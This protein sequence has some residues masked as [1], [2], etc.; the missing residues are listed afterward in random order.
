MARRHAYKILN[1]YFL[2]SSYLNLALNDELKNSQLTRQDKDLCTTIVYGTIQNLL[3]LEYQLEPYIQNKRVKRKVKTLLLMS[4]YQLIYLDKIPDYAIIHEAVQIA[5][6]ENYHSSQFVNA[7]LRNFKRHPLRS[8]DDLDEIQRLSIVTSHPYWMVKMFVK[9][10]GKDIAQKICYEDNTVPTRCARVNTLKTTKAAL[11]KNKH[12]QES[13]LSPD[14]LLYDRGNM[15][16]TEEFKNGWITVQDESSQLVAR[17]LAPKENEYVLDMCGAPGSKTTHLAQLMNNTGQID[18]FDLYE[19]KIK[20]IEKNCLRLGVKNVKAKVYDATK[21]DEIYKKETFDRILLD[22]PCSGFGVLKRKPEI[23]FHDSTVMD[24]L[25]P[26]QTKLLEKA[27][28]LLKNNGTMVYSTCTINKKENDYMIEQFIKKHQDMHIVSQR[29]I[30]NF[31]YHSDGFFM[32][33]MKKG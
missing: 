28:D 4:L 6:K 9:Q 33:K 22:A 31:E 25:I 11:L 18:V 12:F 2:D 7:V 20:L 23:K 5:K 10:Y 19:H 1:Q 30:L 16:Y 26:L 29:T 13:E 17:L 8:L 3:Y 24:E 15:A 14:G 21:L 32:C 27:Y